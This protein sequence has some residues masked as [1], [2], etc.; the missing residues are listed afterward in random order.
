[1]RDVVRDDGLSTQ[2]VLKLH[3]GIRDSQ[4]TCLEYSGFE[5]HTGTDSSNSCGTCM[6]HLSS[7]GHFQ[8]MALT[9]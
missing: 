7:R 4:K 3:S 2:A 5:Q 1:M 6:I 8:M 9:E